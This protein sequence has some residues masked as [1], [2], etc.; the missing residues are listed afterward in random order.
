MEKQTKVMLMGIVGSALF[1]FVE[2]A[3]AAD[4]EM[5]PIPLPFR[6][7]ERIRTF[8]PKPTPMPIKKGPPEVIARIKGA[9]VI[10]P[11]EPRK[12]DDV[13][14]DPPPGEPIAVPKLK[15]LENAIQK[16]HK[17][18]GKQL[19]NGGTLVARDGKPGMKVIHPEDGGV[20]TVK[21]RN[22]YL[23]P[24][25]PAPIDGGGP[26]TLKK[27]TLVPMPVSPPI[28]EGDVRRIKKPPLNPMPV[29]PIKG[30]DDA[31]IDPPP[32]EP[33]PASLTHTKPRG[34]IPKPRPFPQ[35]AEIDHKI[36][37]LDTPPPVPGDVVRAEKPKMHNPTYQPPVHENRLRLQ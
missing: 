34:I 9:P 23:G 14:I 6:E 10:T 8:K 21:K 22:L 26:R 13:S 15:G 7:V 28:E 4:V 5:T 16:S 25:I 27:P 30:D 11:L 31:S 29:E 24:P 1:L 19:G 20:T 18:D 3:Q 37:M 12:G 36:K 2:C 33:M 17:N 32:G 35:T